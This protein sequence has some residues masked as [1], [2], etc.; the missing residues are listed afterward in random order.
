VPFAVVF[1][2]AERSPG[3]WNGSQPV[4][5]DL[6]PGFALQLAPLFA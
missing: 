2:F 1:Y 4:E 5:T 6:L 3:H